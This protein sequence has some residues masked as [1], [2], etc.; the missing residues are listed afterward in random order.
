[1]LKE[2]I[3]ASLGKLIINVFNDIFEFNLE[4]NYTGIS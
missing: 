4:E 3:L 2:K 1:M